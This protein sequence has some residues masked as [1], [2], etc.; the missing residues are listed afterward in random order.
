MRA[1][2]IAALLVLSAASNASAQP[3]GA[4]P[5]Q[6]VKPGTGGY[7]INGCGPEAFM[8]NR[9]KRFADHHSY[10]FGVDR[11]E[12][13][14]YTVNF[15]DSC[16]LHDVGYQGAYF[17]QTA[18][19]TWIRDPLVYN[20]I[21]G[22]YVNYTNMSRA[23][24][25]QRFLVD[26]QAQCEQQIRQQTPTTTV[27]RLAPRSSQDRAV[28]LCKGRAATMHGLVRE[29]GRSAYKEGPQR[30]NDRGD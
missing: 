5:E 3:V 22:D 13:V 18:P 29:F 16:N 28:A 9:E 4:Y 20:K 26:M 7:V 25:D 14:T 27:G 30:L 24:V 23:E 21:R 1:I 11:G 2:C 12:Y 19:G 10:K 6:L 8:V 17:V 15:R